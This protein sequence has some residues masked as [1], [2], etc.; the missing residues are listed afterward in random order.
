MFI[1]ET[2]TASYAR[3][4]HKS[5]HLSIDSDGIRAGGWRCFSAA[6]WTI[7][8]AGNFRDD[9]CAVADFELSPPARR[10][11]PHGGQS[12]DSRQPGEPGKAGRNQILS[13]VLFLV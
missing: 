10:R 12:S 11:L 7:L 9:P 4:I 2:S 13:G 1:D 5:Y 3:A 6:V 8:N